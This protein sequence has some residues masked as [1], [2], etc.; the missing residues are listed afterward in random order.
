MI[1]NGKG[2]TSRNI[3]SSTVTLLLLLLLNSTTHCTAQ[4]TAY[5]RQTTTTKDSTPPGDDDRDKPKPDGAFCVGSGVKCNGGAFKKK[6]Y[7]LKCEGG[8]KL[9]GFQKDAGEV[10]YVDVENVEQQS[11]IIANGLRDHMMNGEYSLKV[12]D[13]MPSEDIIEQIDTMVDGETVEFGGFGGVGW[14]CKAKFSKKKNFVFETAECGVKGIKGMG[15]KSM[16]DHD[17]IVEEESVGARVVDDLLESVSTLVDE[18]N[19]Y[20]DEDDDGDHDK[21]KPDVV[22]CVEKGMKCMGAGIANKGGGVKCEGGAKYNM[23]G[24]S[25]DDL[26]NSLH[27][28]MNEGYLLQAEDLIPSD[29]VLKNI[30]QIETGLLA[31]RHDADGGCEVEFGGFGKFEWGCKVISK[32]KGKSVTAECGMKGL[33]GKGVKPTDDEHDI[34]TITISV[35]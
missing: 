6:G 3:I 5:L 34:T 1:S 30:Q 4:D 33:K 26:A 27:D 23:E 16:V 32:K 22:F 31:S 25:V 35:M 9:S 21:P 15:M 11:R 18:Y 14:G 12:D 10:L 2:S 7:F 19:F 24:K 13:F 17:G 29:H 28:H 8:L 20:D